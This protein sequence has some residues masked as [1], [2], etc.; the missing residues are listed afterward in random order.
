MRLCAGRARP[1][2]RAPARRGDLVDKADRREEADAQPRVDHLAHELDRVGDDARRQARARPANSVAMMAS[3]SQ[4]SCSMTTGWPTHSVRVRRLSPRQRMVGPHQRADRGRKLGDDIDSAM[5][6]VDEEHAEI[7]VAR[8]QRL[9][10]LARMHS[11][12]GE[13]DVGIERRHLPDD[14][15]QEADEQR[16]ERHDADLAAHRVA[17]A[18]DFRPRALELLLRVAHVAQQHLARRG[19]AHAVAA[20]LEERHAHLVLEPQDLP[21]DRGGGD[22]ERVRRLADR[23]VPGDM[24]EVAQDRGVH[25]DLAGEVMPK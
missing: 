18:G 9:A 16:F 5:A 12:H 11:E 25:G 4:R 6:G 23:A 15:R 10:D 7:V 17:D 20:A 2:A 1:A 3:S 21:V 24:I 13:G 8:A 19:Q 22:V 14:L